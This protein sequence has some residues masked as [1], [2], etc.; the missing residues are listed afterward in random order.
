MAL[1]TCVVSGTIY[2]PDGTA[3]ANEVL[4]VV[5]AVKSGNLITSYLET[6]AVSDA[7]G[8]ISITLPRNSTCY[9]WGNVVGFNA[10]ASA[11]VAIVVPDAATASLETIAPATSVPGTVPI[12]VAAGGY[13]HTQGSAAT[14]WTITHNIGSRPTAV[15]CY[16]A[17]Y[18]LIFGQ[19]VHTSTTVTTITFNS[20]QA[21]FAR[22]I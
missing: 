16:D 14:T 20:A 6:S 3:A 1:S 4:R 19:V 2:K 5:K 9:L 7:M 13:V 12:A 21:G 15:Q 18:N 11:G 8:M 10:N 22:L 17:S